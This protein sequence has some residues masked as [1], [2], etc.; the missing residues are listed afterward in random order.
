MDVGSSPSLVP[1]VD[2]NMLSLAQGFLTSLPSSTSFVSTVVTP[3]SHRHQNVFG[4][5]SPISSVSD[6]HTSSTLPY[7]TPSLDEA[8]PLHIDLSPLSSPTFLDSMPFTHYPLAV[9][10]TS[11]IL[12]SL[13]PSDVSPPKDVDIDVVSLHAGDGSFLVPRLFYVTLLSILNCFSFSCFCSASAFHST[14][15]SLFLFFF[16]FQ[17]ATAMFQSC[18]PS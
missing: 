17:S 10:P 9:S 2:A 15:L 16:V 5:V 3:S 1:S 7:V 14:L 6:S 11:S 4:H 18:Q 13:P 12:P 8:L